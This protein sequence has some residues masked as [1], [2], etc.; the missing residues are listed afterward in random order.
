MQV[1]GCYFTFLDALENAVSDGWPTV[2]RTDNKGKGRHEKRYRRTDAVLGNFLRIRDTYIN[3][4]IFIVHYGVV[5]R[6]NGQAQPSP[7]LA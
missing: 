1:D 7:S 3:I 5:S 2:Q 4:T 6:G